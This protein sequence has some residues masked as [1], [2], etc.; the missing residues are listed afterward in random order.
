MV[1]W[2]K[3]G[4]K[5]YKLRRIINFLC[6]FCITSMFVSGKAIRALTLLVMWLIWNKRNSRIFVHQESRTRHLPGPHVFRTRLK[7]PKQ[8]GRLPR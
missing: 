8:I 2:R 7:K 4:P 3:K 6:F 5:K 1:P